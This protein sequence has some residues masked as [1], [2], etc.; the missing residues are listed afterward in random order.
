MGTAL[1]PKPVLQKASQ[2]KSLV[3][4]SPSSTVPPRLLQQ[5]SGHG[6]ATQSSSKTLQGWAQPAEGKDASSPCPDLPKCSAQQVWAS[7]VTSLAGTP[8]AALN[9][10]PLARRSS[11]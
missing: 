1:K 5:V 6:K 4:A 7:A 11:A 10:S 9:V 2:M 8:L 3:T